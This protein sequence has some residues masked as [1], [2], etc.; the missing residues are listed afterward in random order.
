MAG[1]SAWFERTDRSVQE[2]ILSGRAAAAP[3][4]G[5]WL[6]GAVSALLLWGAF[7][8]LDWGFLGWVAVAPV[9]LLARIRRKTRW[10]YTALYVTSGAGWLATLQWMRLGDPTMYVAWFALAWYLAVYV[11]LGVGLTRVAVHRL[12]VPLLIA[13]PV[14]WTGL[15]F[16]RAHVISGFPWYL[17][18][19]SQH[20]WTEFVQISDVVGAYGVSFVLVLG[21]G[22]LAQLISPGWLVR[23]KLLPASE[24]REPAVYAVAPRTL[25]S[26]AGV[27]FLV[28]AGTV[29]YGFVRRGQAEFASGP[30]VALIQGNFPSSVKHDREQWGEMFRVHRY[31]TGLTVPSQPDL[32]VWPETMFRW[33]LFES[34]PDMPDVELAELHPLIPLEAWKDS[35]V[36]NE[37]LNLAEEAN[38]ATVIGLDAFVA[39]TG[40]LRQYNSAAFIEPGAGVTARYDKIHRVPFGEYIP[41]REQLPWLQSFTPYGGDFG[42]DAGRSIHVFHDEQWRYLPLICFEDTVPHLV[43]QYVAASSRNSEP[44]DCLINLT[45]DGWFH[46]SSELDQHLITARFRCIETRTPMVRA[47]NTGISAI[48]DGDG[49]VVEPEKFIDLDGLTNGAPRTSIRDP[50]T[51]Q[52]HKQ[53]HC[54][55]VGTVP[56]DSRHSLYVWLGDWFGGGCAACCM[57]LLMAG[58]LRRPTLR[59]PGAAGEVGLPS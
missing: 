48:I 42:I 4:K 20:H 59:D 25:L 35:S 24:E 32:V 49:V 40:E 47:V 45:N 2:I 50:R 15:E 3:S 27:T 54:A 23:L 16:V 36:R 13:A 6:L 5:A 17:L 31:L 30:R 41:L 7:T 8:P 34:P 57:C 56:L 39:E 28:I 38:A 52:F 44:A 19:H 53:L 58:C 9:L 12:Q 55:L 14:V 51:G 29:M 22:W 33:P 46:G 11:P 37:L 21:N 10:M 43:R 1:R 26:L 18:G